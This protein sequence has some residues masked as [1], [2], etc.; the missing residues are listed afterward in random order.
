MVFEAF[1]FLRRCTFL[2]SW[3]LY[4]CSSILSVIEGRVTDTVSAFVHQYSYIFIWNRA[5]LKK[6]LW[7]FTSVRGVVYKLLLGIDFAIW[8]STS[9]WICVQ[10]WGKKWRYA[11][12]TVYTVSA[13]LLHLHEEKGFE[14]QLFM[15]G[16]YQSWQST[17]RTVR[18]CCR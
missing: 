16:I 8:K 18:L 5:V 3:C 13:L 11:S 15:E 7:L 14:T 1:W 6:I 4:R 2:R 10:T 12:N 9:L 17:L